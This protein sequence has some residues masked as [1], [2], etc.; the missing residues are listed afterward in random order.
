[1]SISEKSE[2]Q[3]RPTYNAL[4]LLKVILSWTL[5]S[6]D[7]QLLKLIFK[8]QTRVYSKETPQDNN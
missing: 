1:M 2:V 3:T 8:K 5:V 4:S 7:L 6:L